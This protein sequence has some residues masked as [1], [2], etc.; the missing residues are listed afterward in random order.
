MAKDA[1]NTE[2]QELEYFYAN[3]MYNISKISKELPFCIFSS[4]ER[5]F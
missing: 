4:G 3:K 2:F 5:A 1:T